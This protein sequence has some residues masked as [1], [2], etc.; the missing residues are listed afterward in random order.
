MKPF[1]KLNKILLDSTVLFALGL[2]GTALANSNFPNKKLT[3]IG[4]ERGANGAGTIPEWTGGLTR[5]P[6]GYTEGGYHPDPFQNDDIKFTISEKNLSDHRAKL[7]ELQKALLAKYPGK[8]VI[9][10]FPTRRSCA[11]PEFIYEATAKNAKT[12][13]V[14]DQGYGFSGASAGFPFP[15]PKSAFEVLFNHETSYFGLRYSAKISGGT[16]NPDGTFTRTVRRDRRLAFYHQPDYSSAEL[17]NRYFVWRAE[18]TDPPLAKGQAFSATNT[19][20]QVKQPRFGFMWNPDTQRVIT[21]PYSAYSYTAPMMTSQGM[22]ISDDMF[23]FNGAPDQYDWKLVGKKEIYIPYNSYAATS[24]NLKLND[25]VRPGFLN[26]EH[27]RYELHRVWVIEGELKPGKSHKFVKRTLYFDEDSWIA[28]A[29]D[30]FDQNN[31]LTHGQFGFIK[32]YYEQPACIQDFDVLYEL[33]SGRYNVDNLKLEFG[34]ANL[35]D[36]DVTSRSF[37]SGALRRSGSR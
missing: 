6:K 20:N 37:G 23:L 4:A 2:S 26:P 22:R 10:V 25:L 5:P 16:M 24:S 1:I 9:N 34:P 14:I 27:I 19:I 11:Y 17:D 12:A 13:K 3:P 8:F 31:V 7:T 28:V 21:A 18:W 29:S 35:N 30:L 32:N 36:P 15:Q 33:E